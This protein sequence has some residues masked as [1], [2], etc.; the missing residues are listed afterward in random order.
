MDST[1][2]YINAPTGNNGKSNGYLIIESEKSAQYLIKNIKE[3][4]G[5]PKMI[6]IGDQIQEITDDTLKNIIINDHHLLPTA[7]HAGIK[8]TLNTIRLRYYWKDMGKDIEKFIK[9]CKQCQ[10]NKQEH[11][12]IPMTITTTA[13]KA[14]DKIY[15]DFVDPLLKSNGFEYILTTQCE[16]SKFIT[17]TPLENKRTETVAKPFVQSVILKYSVPGTI[18]SDRGTEFMSQ[19]FTRVA[20]SLKINKLNSTAYHHQSI[21]ALKNTQKVLGNYLRIQ[22]N[23]KRL[24]W[25]EWKPFYEF[26]YNNTVHSAISSILLSIW[27]TS[28]Y[29]HQFD[30]KTGRN[31]L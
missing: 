17:A 27:K 19:L 16:L 10:L 12:K 20:N 26:F 21:G 4:K 6:I 1:Y 30:R 7:G 24:E 2:K 13:R 22:C 9:S 15:L 28:K 5:I 3:I 11:S 8:R 29:T 18:A 14:F 23:G 25:P 31:Q